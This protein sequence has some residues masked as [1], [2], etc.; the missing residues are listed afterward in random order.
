MSFPSRLA[1]VT[2]PEDLLGVCDLIAI[3]RFLVGQTSRVSSYETL[4]SVIRHVNCAVL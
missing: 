2:S 4:D 3:H 1:G